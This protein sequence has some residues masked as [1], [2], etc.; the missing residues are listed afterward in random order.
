MTVILASASD[1]IQAS[2]ARPLLDHV[3][4]DIQ[5]A[6][7]FIAEYVPLHKPID[8]IAAKMLRGGVSGNWGQQAGIDLFGDYRHRPGCSP[9]TS[10]D[11]PSC[12]KASKPANKM[13]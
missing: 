1:R 2:L 11:Y 8:F 3:Q 5:D 12:W 9:W 13:I 7:S 4:A 10:T 6:G